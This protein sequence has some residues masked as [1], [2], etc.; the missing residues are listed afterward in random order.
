MQWTRVHDLP[1]YAYFN[2]MIH[3]K[4]GIGCATCHGP[5]N[6]MPLTWRE[7]TLHMKWCIDCHRHPENYIRPRDQVFSMTWTP[8]ESGTTQ[9]K[10]GP[11]LLKDYH[12]GVE[13]DDEGEVARDSARNKLVNC[14]TCHR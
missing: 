3:I 6:E 10:L 11:E 12:V 13:I 2:H 7:N 14:S 5:V 1:D 8:A 9:A 4:K